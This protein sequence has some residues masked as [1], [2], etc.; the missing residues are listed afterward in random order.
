MKSRRS[1]VAAE[2]VNAG[3]AGVSGEQL[4]KRLGVSR[5]AI[6]KHVS[7]LRETGYGIEAMR[8]EGYRCTSL[9][10]ALVA[11][12]VERLLVDP[13]WGRI[14]GSPETASTNDDCKALARASAPC[15]TVVVSGHQTSGK[16]RLGRSWVSPA[17]GVYLSTLLTPKGSPGEVSALALACALGVARGLESLGIHCRLKWPNDVLIEGRKV[18]GLLLDMS[19]EAD[20]VDWVVVGCGV[21]VR[22]IEGCFEDAA[23][24]GDT[25]DASPSHVAAAVLDGMAAAYREFE[26]G[27]FAALL[28]EYEK[29][30]ALGGR[31]VVVR[32]GTGGVVATGRVVGVD[33]N[34]RLLV[35]DRDTTVP[36]VAGEVTLRQPEGSD[37]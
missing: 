28:P 18:A 26:A 2:L 21:N 13:L 29:R 15:G 7:A 34:G 5:V 8:G 16:G 9:P 22:R 35:E 19:A 14:E 36:V 27:G 3:D 30:H 20:R 33:E 6:A 31:E 11:V 4:G 23:F 12:E 24:V 25:A 17:G 37:T 10:Q 1:R 32:D